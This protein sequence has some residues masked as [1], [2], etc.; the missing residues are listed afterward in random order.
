MMRSALVSV[1]PNHA[2]WAAIFLLVLVSSVAVF[3]TSR[4]LDEY[5]SS[6]RSEQTLHQLDRFFSTL[7]DVESGSRGYALTRDRRFLEAY[8]LGSRNLPESHRRLQELAS[9]DPGLAAR[10]NSL[11]EAAQQRVALSAQLV[12]LASRGASD[13]ELLAVSES[14]KQ[15]MDQVRRDVASAIPAQQ[16]RYDAGR[17]KVVRQAVI[18]SAALA[19][20]VT[21]A[22]LLLVSLFRSLEREMARRK[23][24][25]EELRALNVNLEDRVQQRTVEVKRTRDLLTEVVEHLPDMVFLKDPADG[26]RY[27]LINAAGE[28]LLGRP[29]SEILGHSDHDLLRKR[30]ADRFLADSKAAFESGRPRSFPVRPLTNGSGTRTVESRKVPISNGNG[31]PHLVLGIVRDVTEA[32]ATEEQLR[33]LQRMD[34]IGRLTGGVAH[35]FNNLLAVIM[36]SVELIGEQVPKGSEPAA[37]AEEAMEAV[38]RGSD[39][40]RRLLAFARKQHLEPESVDLN[41]RLTDV[42]PLLQRTLGENLGVKVRP[43][44]DLWQARI[45]PTQVDDALVNLA[46]NAR[47]AM[48]DGGTLTIETANV[49]IDEEYA[50]HHVEVAAGDYV[51]LA[52]S[53]TGTGMPPDVAARAFEPFFTTKAEGKGTGLGLSQVFGWV[54]QSGGHIKIYSEVDHGTTIK[55]YLPRA[56]AAQARAEAKALEETP[57]NGNETILLVEDNPSVRRTVVRQLSDL[58]YSTIEAKDGEA[59][60]EMIRSGTDFDLLLTDIVMPGGMNGY[61][62][63]ARAEEVRP[64]VRVLFTSGY[65]ELAAAGIKAARNGPLISKPYS[66][67]ELGKALRAAL[68]SS[69]SGETVGSA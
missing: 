31:S 68:D 35:D 18:A 22:L 27:V 16:S 36:G 55:L 17:K 44:K 65:T 67:R 3:S 49:T 63:A 41:E 40:V 42:V 54:K 56:T 64:D 12:D 14:G 1:R 61:D 10:V 15:A 66:K 57:P 20:G 45:D 48:A 13:R 2:F 58:G 4:L 69:N 47:D 34:A 24:V 62:L 28:T 23:Q 32:R 53:D 46:I 5:S 52:V 29:R 50:A 26:F 39:L 60:L 6:V 25:E 38:R 21:I 37:L 9:A 11:R 33:Q 59:A 7:K 51:M 30:E 43:A 8:E 19:L